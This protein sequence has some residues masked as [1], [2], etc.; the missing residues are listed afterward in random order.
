MRDILLSSFKLSNKLNGSQEYRRILGMEVHRGRYGKEF[1]FDP[2]TEAVE[3]PQ[4][5]DTLMEA[6]TPEKAAL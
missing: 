2:P 4:Q 5:A 1:S 3:I 6:D